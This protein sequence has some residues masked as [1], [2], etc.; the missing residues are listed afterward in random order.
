VLRD[1]KRG[2]NSAGGIFI[3]GLVVGGCGLRVATLI[4]HR[5]VFPTAPPE[6][7]AIKGQTIKEREKTGHEPFLANP[8]R[9]QLPD[10]IQKMMSLPA[11]QGFSLYNYSCQE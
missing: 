9:L 6:L 7:H 2:Q 4:S 10:S 1:A 8:I 3:A 5:S 11:I